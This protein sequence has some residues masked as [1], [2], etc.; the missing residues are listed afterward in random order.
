[1]SAIYLLTVF[2]KLSVLP[3]APIFIVRAAAW[4]CPQASRHRYAS[5]PGLWVSSVVHPGLLIINLLFFCG[6]NCG[7]S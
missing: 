6:R 1:M 7:R 3:N 5:L 2:F 4:R